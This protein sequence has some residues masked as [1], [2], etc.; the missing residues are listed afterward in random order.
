[1]S[2]SVSLTCISH[3]LARSLGRS[4]RSFRLRLPLCLITLL[5]CQGALSYAAKICAKKYAAKIVAKK[6]AAN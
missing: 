5:S 3:S 2:S 4:R 1:M 6:Y